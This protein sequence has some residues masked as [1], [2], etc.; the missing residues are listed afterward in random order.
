[1]HRPVVFSP[2][3]QDQLLD[4]YHYIAEASFPS[5][6][7][8]YVDALVDHCERLETFPQ[9][10]IVYDDIRPGLRVTHYRRRT[11][12]AFVVQSD[13]IEIIAIFHGGRNYAS[14]LQE[15]ED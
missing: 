14:L 7:A 10:G 6:A 4:L 5:R 12:I 2:Q 8:R 13:R 3:A 15:H 9:R 1:M 11:A